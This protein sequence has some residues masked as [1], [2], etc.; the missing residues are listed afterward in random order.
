MPTLQETAQKLMIR[1]LA[2]IDNTGYFAA[3][4]TRPLVDLN[5][6]TIR[7]RVDLRVLNAKTM[8]SIGD[9]YIKIEETYHGTDRRMYIYHLADEAFDYEEGFHKHPEKTMGGQVVAHHQTRK[10]G[11]RATWSLTN[12]VSLEEALNQLIASIWRLRA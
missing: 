1:V 9:P 5:T 10:G 3:A 11:T 7:I 6:E 2:V 4:P 12:E 8:L